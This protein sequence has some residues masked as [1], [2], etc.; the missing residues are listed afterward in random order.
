MEHLKGIAIL[1]GVIV[2]GLIAA[3]AFVGSISGVL[4]TV[5]L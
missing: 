1:G 5:G 3:S 2:A 4:A